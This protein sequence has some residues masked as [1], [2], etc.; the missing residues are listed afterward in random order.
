MR[1]LTSISGHNLNDIGGVCHNL[2]TLG[3]TDLSAQEN[4]Q[5]AFL[6]LAI[7]ATNS[8]AMHLR[9]SVSI[10]FARS[11]MS[12][13][14]LSWDIQAASKGRFTLGLGSQVKG[15]NVRR[16]S[17]PWSP[18]APR[19]REYVQ[20][21]RAIWDCWENGT[22]LDYQG[23]HYQFSLM[24][25]NFTPEPLGTPVPK[26]QIAAVGPAMMKVAAEECDGVMLHGFC[27][28]KYLQER[29]L[30]RLEKGLEGAGRS[31]DQFEISGGGFVA[32][33]PDDEAVQKLFEWV[34]MRIGFYGSTPS[35]WPVFEVHGLQDLGLKLNEMSK[36]GQWDEMT[37]EISDDVVHLFAAVGRH[38]ELVG[39]LT[40]RFGGMT[41]I[42]GL[43][44]DT[45][46]DVIQEVLAI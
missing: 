23:E 41:D 34:R 42:V 43:P 21:V 20:S 7:A 35:Y 17:V 4:K 29:I 18:P 1:I 13:A 26:I 12:S 24:T 46:P 30:P 32:T 44:E 36:K 27:T 2:E 45:P 5:D 14:M 33:G 38:D 15:H 22:R 11:P 31:R 10:A 19:M 40:D 37:K 9:T 3:F 39:A 8:K 16:F 25:P 6:P 28:R